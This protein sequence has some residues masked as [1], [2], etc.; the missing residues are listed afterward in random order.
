MDG[1]HLGNAIID[2]TPLRTARAP[3]TCSTS[4]ATFRSSSGSCAGTKKLFTRR[5][6]AG[7]SMSPWPHHWPF[8]RPS[9]SSS[10]RATT[11]SATARAGGRCGHS[12]TRCGARHPAQPAPRPTGG[13]AHP[14]RHGPRRRRSLGHGPDAANDRLIEHPL[15]GLTDH[16]LGL[17]TCPR[18]PTGRIRPRPLPACVRSRG[19]HCPRSWRAPVA[20]QSSKLRVCA[21][22]LPGARASTKLW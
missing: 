16:S 18:R 13:T 4:A 17:A 6:S 7:R 5:I 20:S 3:R 8:Q 21:A 15:P 11:C 19:L 2:G 12:W 22:S 14:L 1:F 10:R 9:R